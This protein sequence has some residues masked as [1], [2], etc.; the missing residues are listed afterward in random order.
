MDIYLIRHTTPDVP[1]GVCYGQRDV[2]LAA[3]WEE[4]FSQLLDKLPSSWDRVYSSPWPRCRRLAQQLAT[5]PIEDVR[6]QELSFGVW[7][8]KAWSDIPSA[9]LDPWMADF[10]HVACPGGESYQMLAHRIK[11]FWQEVN[12][13]DGATVAIVTH[14]GP[15]RALLSAVLGL[16]L[17]NSFRLTIDYGSTSLLRIQNQHAAI[18]FINR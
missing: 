15:I 1:P 4:E 14:A 12:Q 10:V 13:Y 18:Q 17:E 9:A 2:G 11:S 8:G 6:L 5:N 16:P 3:T 7:E